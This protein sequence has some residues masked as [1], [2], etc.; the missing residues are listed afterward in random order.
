MPK[1]PPTREGAECAIEKDVFWEGAAR[2]LAAALAC[3]AGRAAG[4]A[5][6]ALQGKVSKRRA[7]FAGGAAG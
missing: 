6:K 2:A 7:H 1:V 3:P 4:K 5:H